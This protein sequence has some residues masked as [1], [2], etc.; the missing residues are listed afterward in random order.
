MYLIPNDNNLQTI[1]VSVLSA[2]LGGAIT[3][4]GVAWTI[5]HSDKTRK[6][7]LERIER[8][9]KEEEFQKAKPLFTFNIF[10]HVPSVKGPEHLVVVLQAGYL[11]VL[12]HGVALLLGQLIVGAVAD[13]QNTQTVVLQLLAEAPVGQRE[14]GR[15]ENKVFHALFVSSLV[16]FIAI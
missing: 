4:S 14:V 13:A 12:M 5:N 10:D 16:V 15:D 1:V 9:R 2:V 7:D 11:V 6:E 8:E 3:L